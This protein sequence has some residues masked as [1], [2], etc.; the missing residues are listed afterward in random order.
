VTWMRSE[1]T[2]GERG[3]VAAE[4]DVGRARSNAGALFI[5]P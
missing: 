1:R 5:A 2:V 4:R 3:P